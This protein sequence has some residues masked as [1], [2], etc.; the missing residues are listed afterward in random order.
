MSMMKVSMPDNLMEL[1]TLF[2]SRSPQKYKTKIRILKNVFIEELET[3][4]DEL[5]HMQF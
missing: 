3:I 2:I 5:I 1:L 4:Q